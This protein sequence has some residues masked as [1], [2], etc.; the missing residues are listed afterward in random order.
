MDLNKLSKYCAA[1][2][3]ALASCSRHEPLVLAIAAQQSP[4]QA[5]VYLAAELGYFRESGLDVRLEEFPGSAKAM[6]ALLGGSVAVVS[7]Y[8]EQVAGLDAG[9]PPVRAFFLMN[10]SLMV[11]VAVSPKAS[12]RIETIA[13]LRDATV[14]VTTLGSATHSYLNRVLRRNGMREADV[15]PVAIGTASRAV[16][17]LE[18]GAVDAGVVSDFTVRVLE[19][20]GPVRILADTRTIEGV[21]ETYGSDDY[22]G[23][24]L[25]ASAGWLAANGDSARRLVRAVARARDW[26][27]SRSPDEVVAKLP[28]PMRAG[29]AVML[30][31]V[32]KGALALSAADGKFTARA[33]RVAVEIAAGNRAAEETYTNEF[34]E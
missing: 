32:M 12:R 20:S 13:D 31:E 9:A 19:R 17:A 3:I 16:A 1:L 21:R 34:V 25:F 30:R 24:V 10:R 33:A 4:S 15:K 8:H 22:L 6:Q 14:G 5:F 18:R 7:G 27:L 23:A 26:A 2:A 29:D 28:E 11:A